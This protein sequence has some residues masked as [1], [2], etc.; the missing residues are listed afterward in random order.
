[1]AEACAQPPP[2]IVGS[3]FLVFHYH[4]YSATLNMC[5]CYCCLKGLLILPILGF[6]YSVFY[7]YIY[8]YVCTYIYIHIHISYHII[9]HHITS[10][11]ITSHHITSYHIISYHI[12]SYHIISYHIISYIYIYIQ[13]FKGGITG[14]IGLQGLTV[15]NFQDCQGL[16]CRGC[17]FTVYCCLGLQDLWWGS[18][19]RQVTLRIPG[20]TNLACRC[21]MRF[22][23]RSWEATTTRST[24]KNMLSN[25]SETK[26]QTFG[27]PTYPKLYTP[28]LPNGREV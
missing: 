14:G 21:K 2:L 7:I 11:H 28:K 1:M 16:G 12:I 4:Y 27:D 20:T 23:W 6:G 5:C 13:I 24:K 8:I 9:S 26:S 10:H 17:A 18:M 15:L 19:G 3:R 25:D 22:P